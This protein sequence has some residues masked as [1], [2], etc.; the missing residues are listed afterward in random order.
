MM[1]Y[2]F[3][4]V[5]EAQPEQVAVYVPPPRPARRR[6]P[7]WSRVLISQLVSGWRG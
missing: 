6:R 5:R 4:Y 3:T 7:S 2:S 1:G